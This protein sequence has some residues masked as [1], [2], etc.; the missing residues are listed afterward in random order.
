MS[1]KEV[2]SGLGIVGLLVVL[3]YGYL[4]SQWEGPYG[5]KSD[6]VSSSFRHLGSG[7]HIR[8]K[9]TITVYKSRA[10]GFTHNGS[11]FDL[12]YKGVEIKS[13]ELEKWL[14]ASSAG[15][16]EWSLIFDVVELAADDFLLMMGTETIGSYA[17]ARVYLDGEPAAM[18][19]EVIK[20]GEERSDRGDFRQSRV[21]GWSRVVTH[22]GSQ[23]MIRHA[24]FKVVPLGSG[25]L[26]KVQYPFAFLV[27]EH[28]QKQQIQFKVIDLND[29]KM[30]A[31]LDLG[32]ECF[33]L[34]EFFF[35]DSKPYSSDPTEDD[36]KVNYGY[37]PRWW[38]KNIAWAA[39]SST[40]TLRPGHTL[41]GR[42]PRAL[43]IRNE[44]AKVDEAGPQ[45]AIH[46]QPVASPLLEESEIDQVPVLGKN[47]EKLNPRGFKDAQSRGPYLEAIDVVDFCLHGGG[48]VAAQSRAKAC[49]TPARAS[50]FSTPG[51]TVNEVSFLYRPLDET[52]KAVKV[53]VP[54]IDANGER[55][56]SVDVPEE[57]DT[58]RLRQAFVLNESQVMFKARGQGPWQVY[59]VSLKDA[60]FSLQYVDSFAYPHGPFVNIG[61]GG[62]LY[63]TSSGVLV[64][65]KPFGFLDRVTGIVASQDQSVATL[66]VDNDKVHVRVL[67]FTAEALM[68]EQVL[69]TLEVPASC[70]AATGLL[71]EDLPMAARQQWFDKHFVWSADRAKVSLKT[72][73]RPR[74]GR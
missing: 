36:S 35:N 47:C 44:V 2:A 58:H 15:S 38:D 69:S 72:P 19:A 5:N 21:A 1:G 32:T 31:S 63:D 24:P 70:F 41:A 8:I 37:G 59:L 74:W 7:Q 73:C 17:V 28:E 27:D 71:P 67:G 22:A 18:R 68:Q 61:S 34:P 62:Y 64:R 6:P 49:G 30:L 42:A 10:S 66:Y 43:S 16:G 25:Q 55:F 12:V 11:S 9:E 45:P 46:A 65:K 56:M 40:L 39:Q 13:E 54:E 51:V 53:V 52:R 3:F 20:L 48:A 60:D 29:G 23:F 33:A 26:A 14:K 50:I 4:F 57:K